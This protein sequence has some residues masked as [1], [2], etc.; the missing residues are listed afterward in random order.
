MTDKSLTVIVPIFNAEKYLARCLK[1]ISLQKI[2][3]PMEILCVND[4]STDSSKEIVE[5]FVSLDSRFRLINQSNQ[6][7]SSARN[8]GLE[9]AKGEYITFV[10]ADDMVG[11]PIGTTGSE[12]QRML[13]QFTREVDLVAGGI[14][15]IHEANYHKKMQDQL[16]Y[17]ASFD[18]RFILNS[19]NILKVNCSSCAKIFK[20][21]IIE[22]KRLRYPVGLNYEDAYWWFCYAMSAKQACYVTN[23]VYTYFRHPSGVMN[24]TFS[25]KNTELAIQHI[26]IVE[27]IYKFAKCNKFDSVYSDLLAKLYETYLNLALEHCQTEDS[28]Y[29]LW[30]MGKVLRDNEINV[31]N[32]KYLQ[33]LKSGAV[34]D[35]S[36]DPFLVRDARRWRKIVDGFNKV[37]PYNS[38][39]RT[40]VV[41]LL[42]KASLLLKKIKRGN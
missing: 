19:E 21:S 30:R 3:G 11:S 18:G 41:D 35:F 33:A 4:G 32:L 40:I 6:G 28:L 17:S 27:Q 16:Y 15:V 26:L 20:K 39:R 42:T 24:Q 9:T 25:T 10:D 7:R 8:A 12:F 34:T 29:V 37:L 36:F 5:T 22:N 13:D 38:L 31:N 2:S 1:S 14:K 23:A